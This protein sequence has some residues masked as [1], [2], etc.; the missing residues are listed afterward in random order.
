MI[1]GK[2]AFE[3]FFKEGQG[4]GIGLGSIILTINVVLIACY[5][6]GCHSFRHLVGGRKDCMSS[7]GKSSV[8]LGSWKQASWFNE[9]HMLFAWASLIWVMVTDLYVRLCSMGVIHD[10]NTWK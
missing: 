1:L 5:T 3:A 4:F 8:A 10:L 2:D 7:C 9:R 6:F